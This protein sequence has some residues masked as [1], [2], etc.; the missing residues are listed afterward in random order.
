MEYKYS[1]N[2]I[3]SKT[4]VSKQ[5]LYN[6]IKKNQEF[7][8]KN[9]RRIQRK[10][11]YNQEALNFFINYYQPGSTEETAQE[12][13][14]TPQAV[15]EKETVDTSATEQIAALKAEIEELK[16]KLSETEAERKEL[17]QQ[18][19]ALILTVQQQ[20]QEKM[21]L[22]PAPKKTIRERLFGKK[23]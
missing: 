2:D 21:L 14:E 1:I 11:Y 17:L 7:I 22:L 10:I 6:L 8:N 4:K 9:S 23:A 16:K 13:V 5:S 12:A 19:G 3:A 20:Q 18:N 15:E